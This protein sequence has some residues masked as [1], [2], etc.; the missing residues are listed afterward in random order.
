[1]DSKYNW[2]IGVWQPVQCSAMEQAIYAIIRE[3]F[4]GKN[5]LK[6]WQSS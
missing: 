2:L 1:M 4:S 5:L 3:A 6:F